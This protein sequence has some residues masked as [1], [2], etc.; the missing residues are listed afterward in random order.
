M[1]VPNYEFYSN[2]FI[3]VKKSA[4]IFIYI[5]VCPLYKAKV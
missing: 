3:N 2:L 4:R 5:R 1:Y